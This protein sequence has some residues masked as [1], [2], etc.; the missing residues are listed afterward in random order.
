MSGLSKRDDGGQTT[1]QCRQEQR[2]C[3]GAC[4]L[5]AWMVEVDGIPMDARALPR[6][7]QE[8]AFRLGL[9]PFLPEVDESGG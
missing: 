7:I 6:E 1:F 8:E 4:N 2:R 5:L 9:I 3:R